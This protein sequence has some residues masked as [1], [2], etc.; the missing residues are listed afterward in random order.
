MKHVAQDLEVLQ[1]Q[2]SRPIN[3]NILFDITQI[4]SDRHR[5]NIDSV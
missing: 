4:T 3:F 1:I 5:P 2:Q